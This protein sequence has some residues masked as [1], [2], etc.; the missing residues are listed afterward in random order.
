[1]KAEGDFALIADEFTT[2][3]LTGTAETNAD[4]DADSPTLTIR[5]HANART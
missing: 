1:L 5:T 3:Q 2:M 4:A